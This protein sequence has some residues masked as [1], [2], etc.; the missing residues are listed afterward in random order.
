MELIKDVLPSSTNVRV[1]VYDGL[2]IDFAR[3]VGANVIVRGIRVVTDFEYEMAMAHVNKKLAPEIETS[4][5]FAQPE[6]GFISSR[7]VKEVANYGGELSQL[8]PKKV[9]LA[10]SAKLKGV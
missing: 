7:L 8:V 5:A 2:T 9:Q 10:L 4:I 3:S 6:Y 1:E